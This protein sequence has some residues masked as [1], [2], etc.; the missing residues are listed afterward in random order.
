MV[1]PGGEHLAHLLARAIQDGKTVF[2]LL[3]NG[4]YHPVLEEGL[5]NALY[6]LAGKVDGQPE[7][8]L[9]LVP[10]TQP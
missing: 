9:E 2:D 7:S 8:P 1:A 10:A 3:R 6:D 5:Q 4:F